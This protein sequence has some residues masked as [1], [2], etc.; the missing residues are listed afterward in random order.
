MSRW[1][2]YLGRIFAF[3]ALCAALSLA[4]VG[5]AS[6]APWTS[7]IDLPSG[8]PNTVSGSVHDLGGKP[9]SC[10]VQLL[11]Y[12]SSTRSWGAEDHVAFASPDDGSY[13]FTG[14]PAGE[15]RVV[16]YDALG[17]NGWFI[18][19]NHYPQVYNNHNLTF[20]DFM[21]V[22][23]VDPLFPLDLVMVSA[24]GPGPTGIDA[25]MTLEKASISG[26][27]RDESGMPVPGIT[28][29]VYGQNGFGGSSWQK[30]YSVPVAEDGSYVFRGLSWYFERPA[31]LPSSEM[32]TGPTYRV[33]FSDETS[34]AWNAQYLGNTQS[35]FS[36][37]SVMPTGTELVGQDATLTPAA[38]SVSGTVRNAL[39]G[40]PIAGARVNAA[41][42][43][44][45]PDAPPVEI[46]CLTRA[47]GTYELRGMVPGSTYDFGAWAEGWTYVSGGY[48]PIAFAGTPIT[49][50]DF[51]LRPDSAAAPVPEFKSFGA[52]SDPMSS[53]DANVDL[54]AEQFP[55]GYA[56]VTD[57]V[58]TPGEAKYAEDTVSA[59][60]L[61]W[62]YQV[63]KSG[64]VNLG[65]NAPLI[66]ITRAEDPLWAAQVIADMGL[67]NATPDHRITVH[68]VGTATSVP[69]R[70]TRR[71]HDYAASVG[72]KLTV[73]NVV[74]SPKATRYDL[75]A[76]VALRMKSRAAASSTDAIVMPGAAFIANGDQ[77]GRVFGPA[78]CSAVSAARGVPVLPVGLKS[79]PKP[80]SRAIKALGVR[81]GR[82]YVVGDSK[83]VSEKVRKALRIPSGN[84][85]QG[86]TRGS[87]RYTVAVAIATKALSMGWIRNSNVIALASTPYDAVLGGAVSGDAGGQLL[88]ESPYNSESQDAP[89]RWVRSRAA[90][91]EQLW[92]VGD[93][94]SDY[95][96]RYE[97]IWGVTS[98]QS[99]VSP[100]RAAATQQAFARRASVLARGL[101]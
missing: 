23:Q 95:S 97:S 56:D 85:L 93:T 58:V 32:T 34:G 36:A 75:A 96:G 33:G 89:F 92:F 50:R 78:A 69:A 14:V 25:T 64:S 31:G 46:D 8:A 28:A 84:R 72:V 61:C 47:D 91:I 40:E 77:S 99:K 2:T 54:I 70:L 80:I 101:R 3:A 21:E 83:S 68:V 53:G 10:V 19:P 90:R 18:I 81:P 1:S 9:V 5:S 13:R 98:E 30:L 74:T 37:R 16:F 88:I 24:Y 94:A 11:G 6:A 4:V 82:L 48:G 35:F 38:L 44:Q 12:D 60:G 15:Y 27:V 79:V 7:G 67:H 49:G 39:T 43:L 76:A 45:N 63:T 17:I 62:A 55:D 100:R 66:A 71:L 22:D 29:T 57:V 86:P 26:H 73:D 52:W 59:P 41:L 87:T 42:Q 51:T 65:K 20:M